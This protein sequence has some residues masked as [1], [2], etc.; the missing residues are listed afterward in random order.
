MW[1]IREHQ[2][3]AFR[4]D[5][6]L[7]IH[8]SADDGSSHPPIGAIAGGVIGSL[9]GLL[10]VCST[11]FLIRRRRQKRRTEEGQITAYPP[12][13]TNFTSQPLV[14]SGML[15]GKGAQR[16]AE[17]DRLQRDMNNLQTRPNGPSTPSTTSAS[18]F[19]PS[20][21]AVAGPTDSGLANQIAELRLEVE[22]LRNQPP[23]NVLDI[24]PP[25]RYSSADR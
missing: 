18:R 10:I 9:A 13:S 22:N 24:A 8:I 4:L 14:E 6:K 15:S 1:N 3:H 19:P 7:T 21:A 25:P 12:H 17:L 11:I 20:S 2:N 16:Q 23:E 5:G